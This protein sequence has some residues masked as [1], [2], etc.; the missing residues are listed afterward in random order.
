M[1]RRLLGYEI[2][3]ALIGGGPERDRVAAAIAERGLRS[4]TLHEAM[5]ARDALAM[6]RVFVLPSLFESLPYVVIE[7]AAAG[8][9][10][11]A[12]R[13]GGIAEAMGPAA[14]R[15]VPPATRRR[16]PP[17]SPPP[18]TTIPPGRRRGATRSAIT[19]APISA[20]RPWL[21]DRGRLPRRHRRPRRRRPGRLKLPLRAYA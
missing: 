15:L 4:V 12:T 9:D 18:S 14:D 16:S 6:G 1:L 17:S 11:V 10:I 13:V 19:S 5:P 2:S 3:A 21:P 8:L 7:A 20:C